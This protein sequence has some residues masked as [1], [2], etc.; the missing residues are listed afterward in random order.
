MLTNIKMFTKSLPIFLLIGVLTSCGT[1]KK[2]PNY[3]KKIRKS[4]L[5]SSVQKEQLYKNVRN[6][7]M[8]GTLKYRQKDE[9]MNLGF[10][11]ALEK[12]KLIG[13]TV[14]FLGFSVAKIKITPNTLSYF[15]KK[16][17][18][19]YEGDYSKARELLNFPID[20]NNLQSLFLATPL[21]PLTKKARIKTLATQYRIKQPYP[22]NI[23][24]IVLADALFLLTRQS[25]SMN[26]GSRILDV[27]YSGY[28]T[29]TAIP[30][31]SFPAKINFTVRDAEKELTVDINF[32]TLKFNEDNLRFSYRVPA[33]YKKID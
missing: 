16:S 12:D 6:I 3:V 11:V 7:Y 29:V 10:S 25:L 13:I 19:Y 23:S 22:R 26:R 14:Y 30:N 21:L 8:R 17:R 4:K 32:K 2:N 28:R 5:L 33:N 9:G 15:D 20:F 18:Q 1:A 27:R 24:L 31:L